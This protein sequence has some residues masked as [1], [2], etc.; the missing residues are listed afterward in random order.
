MKKLIFISLLLMTSCT[1]RGYQRASRTFQFSERNYHIKQ[2]SGG[3]CV[4]E[5]KFHGI[6]NNEE[7]SDGYFF[8]RAD[9][10]VEVSGDL[11]IKSWD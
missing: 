1:P 7:H 5:Y 8:F 9:T 11:T 4:G 2:Y 6:L 10:L 3:K